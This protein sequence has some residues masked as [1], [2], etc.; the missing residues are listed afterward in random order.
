MTWHIFRSLLMF[1]HLSKRV[2]CVMGLGGNW[3][4]HYTWQN[5]CRTSRRITSYVQSM[6]GGERRLL[7]ERERGLKEMRWVRMVGIMFYY[8]EAKAQAQHHRGKK[9]GKDRFRTGFKIAVSTV[10]S[11]TT[12]FAT[13]T[14]NSAGWMDLRKEGLKDVLR[15]AYSIRKGKS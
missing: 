10:L 7:R 4:S 11:P 14:K 5:I 1:G 12:I 3:L 9:K 13:N 6:R 15:I 8:A 2:E